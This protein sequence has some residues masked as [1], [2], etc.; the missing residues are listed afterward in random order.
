MK[1]CDFHSL[2]WETKAN[3]K[4]SALHHRWSHNLPKGSAFLCRLLIK[5]S[6]YN[7]EEIH[8][9]NSWTTRS[10]GPQAQ[11]IKNCGSSTQ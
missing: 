2:E 3:I 11:K 6:L 10:R 8:F 4:T 1:T 7:N 5:T 9:P